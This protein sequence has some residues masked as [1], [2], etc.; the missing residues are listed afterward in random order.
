MISN[1]SIATEVRM[2]SKDCFDCACDGCRQPIGVRGWA[3]DLRRY[4]AEEAHRLEYLHAACTAEKAR[5]A[6]IAYAKSK[7]CAS[8][9]TLLDV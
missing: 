8:T 5:V 7:S 4:E 6:W 9:N 3:E 2:D 1:L